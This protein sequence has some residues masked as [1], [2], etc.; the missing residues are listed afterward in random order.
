MLLSSCSTHKRPYH[1]PHLYTHT[2][3]EELR[4]T[5]LLTRG[6]WCGKGH[7]PHPPCACRG[8]PC[9]VPATLQAGPHNIPAHGRHWV[10]HRAIVY[11]T[12]GRSIWCGQCTFLLQLE[13]QAQQV[14]PQSAEVHTWLPYPNRQH[15][16]SKSNYARVSHYKDGWDVL[17]KEGFHTLKDAPPVLCV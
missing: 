15:A 4:C 17:I 1:V 6:A 11:C 8:F 2:F 16:Q 5:S 14:A 10:C 13:R 3:G 9:T 12:R 7:Q